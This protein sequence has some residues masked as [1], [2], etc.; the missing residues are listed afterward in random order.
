MINKP[1]K[2][3]TN[4]G[5]QTYSVTGIIVSNESSWISIAVKSL[6]DAFKMCYCYRTN[7]STKIEKLTNSEVGEYL[8][9]VY[10]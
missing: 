4:I 3:L 10:K 2:L 8:V 7:I 1:I 6:D 9:V 5:G